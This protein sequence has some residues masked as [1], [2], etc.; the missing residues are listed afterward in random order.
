MKLLINCLLVLLFGVSSAFA[1]RGGSSEVFPQQASIEH[2]E[3]VQNLS[4][5]FVTTLF[6]NM[7][8]L[9]S[10]ESLLGGYGNYASVEQNGENNRTGISQWGSGNSAS[11]SLIGNFN[12]VGINQ[13]GVGNTADVLFEGNYN[14]LGLNQLGGFHRFELNMINTDGF[15]QNFTQVGMG[16]NIKIEG[17]GNIPLVIEQ[18]S[19]AAAPGTNQ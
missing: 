4:Q 12:H 8:L 7:P 17:T 2:N 14:S 19:G 16:G 5:R 6:D 13:A 10:L 9:G 3:A 18:R 11:V 1:Q 15:N